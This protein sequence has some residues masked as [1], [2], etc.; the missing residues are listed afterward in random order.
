[1]RKNILAFLVTIF[2][3]TA[4]A[5]QP[6]TPYALPPLPTPSIE[7]QIVGS[8]KNTYMV[9][10]S[11]ESNKDRAGLQKLADYLHTNFGRTIIWFWDD[12]NKADTSYPVDPDKEQTLIAKYTFDF[13][14]YE[15]VLKV[16]TLGD[17]R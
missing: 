4:C 13:L 7:Y 9:V 2:L 1:M 11:P 16:F 12:I 15:G 10:V 17:A 6:S 8:T 14:A 3:L 5:S